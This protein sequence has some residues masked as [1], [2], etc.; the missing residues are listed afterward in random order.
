MASGKKPC[1]R[2]DVLRSCPHSGD[3]A[4]AAGCPRALKPRARKSAALHAEFPHPY[5]ASGPAGPG[6]DQGTRFYRSRPVRRGNT[7]IAGTGICSGPGRG[8]CATPGFIRTDVG[9]PVADHRIDMCRTGPP[10]NATAGK[11]GNDTMDSPA[12]H[13][14]LT[15]ALVPAFPV[16]KTGT[17]V[18][19]SL[20]FYAG[21]VRRPQVRSTQEHSIQEQESGRKL[22]ACTLPQIRPQ[23]GSCTRAIFPLFFPCFFSLNFRRNPGETGWQHTARTASH[24]AC[25]LPCRSGAVLCRVISRLKIGVSNRDALPGR[26]YP[27]IHRKSLRAYFIIR[28][29]SSGWRDPYP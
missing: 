27:P 26:I 12:L 11:A 19:F 6:A 18:R 28:F 3:R 4:A 16:R 15:G 22:R 1:A 10:C 20:W 2:R 8:N 5:C 14:D 21:M 7:I 29:G 24:T 25:F 13:S 23:T 9:M 17:A